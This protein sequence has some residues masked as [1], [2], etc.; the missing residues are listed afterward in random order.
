MIEAYNGAP[1]TDEEYRLIRDLI[2]EFCGIHLPD[3]VKFLVERRLRP[4]LPVHGLTGFRD[5]Y[6]LIRYGRQRHEEMDEVVDRITTNETYFFR[7]EH[8]LKAFTDE[9]L[10]AVMREKRS[11]D[12]IKIWS[13]GC[14]SGEEPYTL[15]MLID[16]M[17]VA[18]AFQFEILGHDI[19]RKVLR[20]ARQGIYREASFRQ[21]PEEIREKYFAREG[22]EYR[23]HRNVAERVEFGHLNLFNT[24][25]MASIEN[26]DIV[27][28]RNVMIYFSPESRRRLLDN[29]LSSMRPGGYLVLGHTESLINASTGFQIVPLKNDIVYRKPSE[30]DSVDG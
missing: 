13:A 25:A 14:S 27:L 16:P 30:D 2:Y 20:V 8:Q 26:V 1:M 6:R 29:L 17:S 15:A 7:G 11:G 28:C 22:N 19:S 18:R 9:I 5:Y 23:L 21:T 4:R 12:R 3:S 10:P 24:E